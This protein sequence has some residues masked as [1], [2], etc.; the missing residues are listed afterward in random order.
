[1]GRLANVGETADELRGEPWPT[2][3]L[4]LIVEMLV[5][6]RA[7][8]EQPLPDIDRLLTARTTKN[9]TAFLEKRPP[10]WSDK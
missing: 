9:M 1:M 6:I 7:G 2:I 10:K 3:A 4:L 5:F 8:S